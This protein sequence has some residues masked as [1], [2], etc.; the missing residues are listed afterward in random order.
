[1]KSDLNLP[2]PLLS[3]ADEQ[4][5]KRYGLVHEKGNGDLDI[6]RPAE[7]LLDGKGIIRWAMFT[8]NI[9]VSP[10]PDALLDAAKR[11]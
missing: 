8:D 6:P 5:I 2:F 7:L 3:D 1:M 9:R 11:L 4:V 10:H